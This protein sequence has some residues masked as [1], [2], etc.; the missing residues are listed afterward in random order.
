MFWAAHLRRSLVPLHH[1]Q[2]LSLV[3][4]FFRLSIFTIWWGLALRVLLHLFHFRPGLSLISLSPPAQALATALHFLAFF[5]PSNCPFVFL[6][7]FTP[8]PCAPAYELYYHTVSFGQVLRRGRKLATICQ[9]ITR[10]EPPELGLCGLHSSH[11]C[12][13]C[14]Y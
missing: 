14:S 12:L 10:M 1:L 7:P 8:V 6:P 5:S 4:K 13:P 2:Q 11:H 3:R 9:N